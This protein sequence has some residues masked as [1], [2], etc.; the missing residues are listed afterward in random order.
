MNVISFF[1]SKIFIVFRYFIERKN[2]YLFK[3]NKA[4]WHE[5][6]S[7]LKKSKSTGCNISDYLE[8]YRYV[9]KNKPLEILECGTGA[10][11]VVMAYALIENEKEGFKG[12][13]T[14]M[15]SINEYLLMA[16]NLLPEH[17]SKYVDFV[18]SP[19]IED[20][21]ALFRGMRYEKIPMDR[22]YDFIYVDG[23]SYICPK[24][25]SITF[26]FDLIHVL[27]YS[28][29]NVSAIVDKRVTSCYVF[30]KVL[31][32]DKVKY[33][34]ITHLGFIGPCNKF[35]L[36]NFNNDEPSSVFV[37]S[38]SNFF[39][40]KLNFNLKNKLFKNKN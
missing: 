14:S 13:I 17:M 2:T 9:R 19:V 4:L 32:T 37:K 21:Y 16:K 20:S 25:G 30:Q 35:D 1:K 5:L 28:N 18:L 3:Q 27:K 6:D 38:F 33:N 29:I 15:E 22:N 36:L 24:D 23:P 26:D 40:T 10:S 11:T 8:I 12:R 39:N 34:A 31:G 7:Y